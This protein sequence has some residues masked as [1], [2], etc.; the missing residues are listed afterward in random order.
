MLKPLDYLFR[1]SWK[2]IVIAAIGSLIIAG[3]NILGLKF[4]KEIVSTDEKLLYLSLTVIA[5]LASVVLN[6]FLTR[7]TTTYFEHQLA[8]LRGDISLRI[9]QSSYHQMSDRLNRISTVL[10]FELNHIGFLGKSLPGVIVALVQTL[11]ILTYLF[12]LYWKLAAIVFGLFAGIGIIMFLTLPILKKIQRKQSISMRRLHTMLELMGI[13]FKNLSIHDAHRRYFVGEILGQPSKDHA[14]QSSKAHMVTI[15]IEQLITAMM[16]I[17]FAALLAYGWGLEIGEDV[18]MQFVVALLFILPSFIK[19]IAFMA[20]LK[21]VENSI[22][23]INELQVDILNDERDLSPERKDAAV[24]DTR[25]IIALKEIEY[26]YVSNRSVFKLG[27]IDLEIYDNEI[28]VIRG[29]NGSGKTTL[30]NI[31]SGLSTP[32]SGSFQYRGIPLSEYGLAEYK[33]HLSCHFTDTPVFDDLTYIQNKER[34]K[35]KRFISELGLEGKTELY[36]S[37]ISDFNLSFGQKGRL[38]LL[39]VLLEDRPV[40]MMDEWA[41]NQDVYFKDKFYNVI[42]PELKAGGKTVILIS[43]DDKYDAI[44]DRVI[45]MRNGKIESVTIPSKPS[46]PFDYSEKAN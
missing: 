21:K 35:E 26:S 7:K 22:D 14:D 45:T 34:D 2:I 43:H 16:L 5:V 29:G 40:V 1:S 30:F 46:E 19:M 32:T 3:L 38:S 10:Y 33:Q 12:Y 28:V 31:I 23:Q 18:A 20:Q 9:L 37:Q 39:R 27:P 25:T 4:L 13:G 11:G 44:A 15:G 24:H 17:A 6:L 41:A 42:I 36:F 8:K